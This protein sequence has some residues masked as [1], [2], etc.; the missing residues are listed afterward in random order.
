MLLKY[1]HGKKSFFRL[2]AVLELSQ[3]DLAVLGRERARR[4][5]VVDGV[6]RLALG[7]LEQIAHEDGRLGRDGGSRLRRRQTR[8]VAGGPDV[9]EL[10]VLGRAVVDVDV[11]GAVGER[12]VLDEG[13]GAH[14]GRDVQ[15]VK[16]FL[17]LVL[18]VGAG[19]GGRVAVNG[20]EVVQE[21]SLD[22]P[23]LAE[24]LERRGVLGHGEH[25]AEA[26][27]EADLDGGRGGVARVVEPNLLPVVE[28][29]PHDLLGGAG[30]LDDAG[31]LCEDGGALLEFLNRGEDLVAAVVAVD[32]RD[33]SIRVGERLGKTLDAAKV[34][35]DTRGHNQLV[36]AQGAAIL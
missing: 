15:E 22:V 35:A 33:E 23:L 2:A 7:S 26:A 13:V 25:A 5:A 8:D 29:K 36:V 34:N 30:A 21:E 17:D 24:R 27:G 9:G 4:V 20:D 12:A 6:G 11:A 10:L 28:G 16:V 31:G 3:Q 19:K 1:T 32:G 18:A 14:L